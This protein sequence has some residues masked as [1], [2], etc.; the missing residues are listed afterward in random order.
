MLIKNFVWQRN[1]YRI[2]IKGCGI[3]WENLGTLSM[4]MKNSK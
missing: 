2:T 3:L 4:L 1:V